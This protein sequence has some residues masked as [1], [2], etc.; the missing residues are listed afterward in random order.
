M[1]KLNLAVMGGTPY[2]KRLAGY[3]GSHAPEYV[4]VIQGTDGGKF[5]E[6]MQGVQPDILLYDLRK[7]QKE[8]DVSAQTLKIHLSDGRP[9]AGTEKSGKNSAVIF[10]YQNGEAIL[11]EIFKLYR[12]F[13]DREFFSVTSPGSI[14]VTAVCA[15][16]G[17]EMQILFSMAYA[18]FLAKNY[19][20][21]F[22]NLAEFSGMDMLLEDASEESFSDCIYGIRQKRTQ[23]SLLL[24]SALHHTDAFDYLKPPQNP[25]DLYEMEGADIQRFFEFLE[26]ETDYQAVVCNCGAWNP[27]SARIFRRSLHILCPVRDNLLGKCRKEEFM[28]YLEKRKEEELQKKI[29]YVSLPAGVTGYTKGPEIISWFYHCGF[30]EIIKDLLR[31]TEGWND[32]GDGG[33]Q[34]AD[35]RQNGYD[36]GDQR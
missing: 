24:Q 11:R 27:L 13:S 31:E 18:A 26:K 7:G 15:S 35:F 3:I 12:K 9:M 22:L 8:P 17:Y 21:L 1:E 36:A 14:R 20:V 4:E 30:S 6:L 5:S 29:R 28:R 32:T 34:A 19:K 23:F 16:G 33:R 2:M 25:Q 10:R